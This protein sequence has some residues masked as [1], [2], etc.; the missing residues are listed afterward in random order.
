MFAVICQVHGQRGQLEVAGSSV[1]DEL[2][3]MLTN[4]LHIQTA[5]GLGAR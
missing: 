1:Q 2:P 3:D 5:T 4:A